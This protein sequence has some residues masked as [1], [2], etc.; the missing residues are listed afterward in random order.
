MCGRDWEKQKRFLLPAEAFGKDNLI[1]LHMLKQVATLRTG[2]LTFVY[3]DWQP[4]Q[5]ILFLVVAKDVPGGGSKRIGRH[6]TISNSAQNTM[7]YGVSKGSA[8][9]DSLL[10]RITKRMFA[11]ESL[12]LRNR[13]PFV[14]CRF[15]SRLLSN[16]TSDHDLPVV[17]SRDHKHVGLGMNMEPGWIT[18]GSNKSPELPI[19]IYDVQLLV[20]TYDLLWSGI[21]IIC[22]PEPRFHHSSF[23]AAENISW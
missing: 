4:I 17:A 6:I 10:L 11:E 3:W 7:R 16:L 23:P 13:L 8:M 20:Q 18:V 12:R 9:M 2:E 14:A 1:Y 5:R 15:E 22:K 19:E 21:P